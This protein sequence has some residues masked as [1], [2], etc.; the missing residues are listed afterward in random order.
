M[1]LLTCVLCDEKIYP[2]PVSGWAEGNNPA[3]LADKGRC[4]KLCDD[5]KVLPARILASLRWN[6]EGGTT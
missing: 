4:C 3:P 6:T 2:E 1:K 5:T